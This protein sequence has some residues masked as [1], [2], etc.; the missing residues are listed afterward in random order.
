MLFTLG[1]WFI[2]TK[3][4]YNS[5]I[6]CGHS[7]LNLHIKPI[8]CPK[9]ISKRQSGLNANFKVKPLC[10]SLD[11]QKAYTKP[12]NT[13]K[14]HHMSATKAMGFAPRVFLGTPVISTFLVYLG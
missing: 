1:G 5:F 12:L 8:K 2:T 3:P 7:N 6:L 4:N 14:V 11:D 10:S 9:R 13:T